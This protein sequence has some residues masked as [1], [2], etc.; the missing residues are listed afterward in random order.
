MTLFAAMLAL[1]AAA[2][3]L[4]ATTAQAATSG[5][6]AD[7]LTFRLSEISP[8]V[9][10]A[11]GPGTVTLVGRFTNAGPDPI[12]DIAFRFQRGP[13]LT[14]PAAVRAQLDKPTQPTEVI[15]GFRSLPGTLDPGASRPFAI[16][17]PAYDAPTDKPGDPGEG[18][19]TGPTASPVDS[20]GITAP[21]V[22]PV[23]LNV[24]GTLHVG[25]EATR[26]RVGELHTVVTVASLPDAVGGDTKPVGG[27]TPVNILWPLADTPHLG[28]GDVFSD[29]DLAGELTGGGRLAVALAA[30]ENAGAEPDLVTIVVD[31]MLLDELERMAGG[32]RVL[33]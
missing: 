12:D 8:V 20:L 24:N 3:G 9:V 21:G 10:T 18:A 19:G 31:P 6:F 2:V 29:D 1:A 15:G 26:A 32:Y 22:Y 7:R 30:L 11:A 5:E 13:A 14:T 4:G 28:V 23:M 16:T 17:V 33:A 27:S 25:G